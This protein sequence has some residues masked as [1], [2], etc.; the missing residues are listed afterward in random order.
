MPLLVDRPHVHVPVHVDVAGIALPVERPVVQLGLGLGRP[1]ED[2]VVAGLAVLLREPLDEVIV[3]RD[4]LRE[5]PGHGV[6]AVGEV[7]GAVAVPPR[8]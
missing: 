8:V 5:V 7:L 6:R 3:A 4:Q 2:V 1:L